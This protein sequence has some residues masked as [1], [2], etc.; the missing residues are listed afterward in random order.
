MKHGQLICGYQHAYSNQLDEVSNACL[1]NIMYTY[2]LIKSLLL[3]SNFSSFQKDEPPPVEVGMCLIYICFFAKN[4]FRSH[5]AFSL[6]IL[7]FTDKKS[8][9]DDDDSGIG[10][11]ISTAGKSTTVSEVNYIA[12]LNCSFVLPL[13]CNLNPLYML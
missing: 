2:W 4:T 10:P 1:Y 6:L 11:S 3:A 9:H 12:S 5:I 8:H 13:V 7:F